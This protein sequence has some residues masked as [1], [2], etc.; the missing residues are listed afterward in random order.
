MLAICVGK[1][2]VDQKKE[3]VENLIYDIMKSKG[4]IKIDINNVRTQFDQKT[5][6]SF[7]SFITN[8]KRA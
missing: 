4:K 2:V 3:D 6:Y 5:M 8:L 7:P 1:I